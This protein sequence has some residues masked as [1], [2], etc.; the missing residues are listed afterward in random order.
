[1]NNNEEIKS[2]IDQLRHS[3]GDTNYNRTEYEDLLS[4]YEILLREN[5]LLKEEIKQAVS[6]KIP[7]RDEIESISGML[8]L[9]NKI[10]SSTIEKIERFNRKS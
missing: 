5:T 1:M 10:D 7:S 8:D 9:I 6:N 4:K 2:R 3:N